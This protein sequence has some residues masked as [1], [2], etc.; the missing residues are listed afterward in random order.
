M[1]IEEI[2]KSAVVAALQDLQQAGGQEM[3]AQEP[4][5]DSGCGCG[6][7]P[8]SKEIQVPNEEP[9]SVEAAPT[10]MPPQTQELELKKAAMGK[11]G[12]HISQMIQGGEA[13]Y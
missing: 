6:E 13:E 9:E 1:K 5:Q 7:E 10:F 4:A 11:R 12:K 2:I 3:P 8:M